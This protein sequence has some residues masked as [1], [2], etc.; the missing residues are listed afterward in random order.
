MNDIRKSKFGDLPFD[1]IDS[2]IQYPT[3]V[4]LTCFPS[5]LSLSHPPFL[6]ILPHQ[7]SNSIVTSVITILA[8]NVSD[9]DLRGLFSQLMAGSSTGRDADV[10]DHNDARGVMVRREPRVEHAISTEMARRVADANDVRRS[11]EVLR[12]ELSRKEAELRE[13]K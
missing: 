10:F 1:P 7:S 9:T 11:N 2:I 5:S 12:A 13:K 6:S 3:G 4:T 8:M